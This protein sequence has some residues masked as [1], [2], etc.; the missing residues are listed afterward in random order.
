MLDN[1]L[2]PRPPGFVIIKAQ[3]NVD[4]VRVVCKKRIQCSVIRTAQRQIVNTAPISS[5]LHN[6]QRGTRHGIYGRFVHF[7]RVG[8]GSSF[9]VKRIYLFT[10]GNIAAKL[11]LRT[12]AQAAAL[13][14]SISI[15]PDK[16]A[17]RMVLEARLIQDS[18]LLA[19]RQHIGVNAALAKIG[20]SS[21]VVLIWLRQ[22]EFL[23]RFLLGRGW[24]CFYR[25]ERR[26]D[27]AL[28]PIDFPHRFYKRNAFN[29]YEIVQRGA[30]GSFRF[31]V[32]P[33]TI[34]CEGQRAVPFVAELSGSF[35]F[36]VVRL[37]QLHILVQIHLLRLGDFLLCYTG[38]TLPP[39]SVFLTVIYILSITII[40]LIIISISSV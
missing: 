6:F 16:Y 18:L 10:A 8:S 2:R 31:E 11:D 9:D 32:C 13:G 23:C 35:R 17:V 33:R 7:H 3:D 24:G 34:L 27:T 25:L 39:Y 38:H 37:T 40:S 29:R 21:V 14:L 30:T 4:Y 28:Y 5:V 12:T 1:V 26:T 20:S 15:A 36:E 19:D 22:P